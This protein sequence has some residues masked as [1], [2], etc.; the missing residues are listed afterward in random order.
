M[1]GLN[2]VLSDSILFTK[3]GFA[4][5]PLIKALHLLYSARLPK[6]QTGPVKKQV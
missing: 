3:D 4:E 6:Y 5:Q 2:A 1:I